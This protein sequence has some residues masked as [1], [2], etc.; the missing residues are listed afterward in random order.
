MQKLARAAAVVPATVTSDAAQMDIA[1]AAATLGRR[2]C[3]ECP[4]RASAG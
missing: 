1:A 2:L 4:L 3:H